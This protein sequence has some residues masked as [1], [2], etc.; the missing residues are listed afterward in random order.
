MEGKVLMI[1][2]L[3]WCDLTGN[4][5]GETPFVA[6]SGVCIMSQSLKSASCY[7]MMSWLYNKKT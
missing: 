6:L 2:L 4:M 1:S 3:S 7:R 5:L